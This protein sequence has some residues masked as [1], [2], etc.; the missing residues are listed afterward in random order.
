MPKV[1]FPHILSSDKDHA[2][3]IIRIVTDS[4]ETDGMVLQRDGRE[5]NKDT[6]VIEDVFNV[7]EFSELKEKRPARGDWSKWDSHPTYYN[8]VGKVK[9]IFS[10]QLS[11]S[12][13]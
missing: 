11:V 4:T 13:I 3:G 10:S 2:K 1:S 7:Y 6:G 9:R 8:G 12:V 5:L